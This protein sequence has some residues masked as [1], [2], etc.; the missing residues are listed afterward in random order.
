MEMQI[1]KFKKLIEVGFSRVGI[2]LI[3]CL[4]IMFVVKLI[5]VNDLCLTDG[6]NLGNNCHSV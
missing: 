6:W 5:Y 1:I 3:I 4:I 2:R